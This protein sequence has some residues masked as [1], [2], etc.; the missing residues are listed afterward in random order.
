MKFKSIYLWYGLPIALI[1]AWVLLFYMPFSSHIKNRGKEI[2]NI[3]QEDQKVDISI[4]GMVE[5]VNKQAQW[6][7][8]LSEFKTQAPDLERFPEFMREVMKLARD[9]GIAIERF[10][11][12]F[13]SIGTEQKSQLI[14][15]VFE[16]EIKGGFLET[17]KF[18][19]ELGNKMVYRGIQKAQISYD[20]KEYPV[21]TGKYVV[22]FKAMKGKAFEGK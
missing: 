11:S 5:L 9:R 10:S 22:E 20:E 19:E 16:I 2:L 15:P 13:T 8:S 3:K 7:Q 18:L 14:N 21:L 1:V 12:V 6:R 4:K 17:G